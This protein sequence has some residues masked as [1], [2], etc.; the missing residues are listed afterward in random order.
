MK[1]MKRSFLA[2]MLA[3][4]MILGSGGQSVAVGVETDVAAETQED[5]ALPNEPEQTEQNGV[6][7]TEGSISVQSSTAVP[8]ARAVVMTDQ[9]QDG[10][11]V[12]Q[13][14]ASGTAGSTYFR[15]PSLITL[16]DGSLL[17]AADARW[18]DMSDGGGL[19]TLVSKST[20]NGVTWKYTFANYFGDNGNVYNS[21]SS[22][23][24]DPAMVQDDDGTIYL[25]VD[26][27]PGGVSNLN[28]CDEG[29]G[30]VSVNG[31]QRLALSTDGSNYDYYAGDFTDGYADICRISDNAPTGYVVNENYDLFSRSGDGQY[32][33]LNDNVFFSG[34]V[35]RVFPTSYLWLVTSEDGTDWSAPRIL[36]AQVKNSSETF[37]GV[38]PGRGLVTSSGRIIFPCYRHS[39]SL[40]PQERTSFIYSDDHGQTWRRTGD[41]SETSSE[42]AVTEADGR[43]YAFTRTGSSVLSDRSALT[44]YTSSDNGTSWSGRMDASIDT[45]TA[46]QMSAITYKEKIDGRTA[47]IL[48]APSGDNRTNG[49]IYVGLVREDGSLDWAY[50]CVVN[51]GS[52]EYSCLTE[53]ADGSI[54]I[55][56]EPGNGRI[57]YENISI[58][59]VAPGAQIG[60]A[61][62]QTIDLY[63]GDKETET[64]TV[65]GHVSPT[66][67]DGSI[68][69]VTAREA[70]DS[71]VG[72]ETKERT[73][74]TFT[75][76]KEGTT[77]VTA[78]DYVFTVNVHGTSQGD[79]SDIGDLTF[80]SNTGNS[81]YSL[82]KTVSHLILTPGKQYD[83]NVTGAE[84][85]TVT[86]NSGNRTVAAVDSNGVVTAFQQGD[87][88]IT[89]EI[90]N[91]DGVIVG[92]HT[93]TVSVLEIEPMASLW[94][95]NSR[96]VE[97]YIDQVQDSRLYYRQNDERDFKEVYADTV[98]Y[99]TSEEA[100]AMTFF[101]APSD[102]SYALTYLS[103][104]N[105]QNQN[106]W[107]V[108]E[109]ADSMAATTF[110]QNCGGLISSDLYS[111]AEVIQMLQRA[112]ALG[113]D[114]GFWFT[115]GKYVDGDSCRAVVNVVS[116]R[117]P[118]VEKSVTSVI[119]N[120]VETPYGEG[121][122]ICPGDTIV[123][124][125]AVHRYA[126]EYGITYNNASLTEE[127]DGAVFTSGS[128][129][130][131]IT[132]DLGTSPSEEEIFHY[133]ARYS[134]KESDGDAFL[135]N[136]VILSYDYHAQY[137]SGTMEAETDAE[138]KTAVQSFVPDDYVIDYGS[139][140]RVDF[141]GKVLH[142][143]T[144]GTAT[145]GSVE[146][147][148][149]KTVIYTPE[150]VLTEAD[151]V[152]LT[153]TEG[154]GY[155]FRVY[156]ATSVYY[157]EG[158]AEYS[159]GWSGYNRATDE[160][161]AS[162]AN[163][164]TVDLYGYDALYSDSNGNS[165][166][167]LA[168]SST[169]NAAAEFTFNGTG[170][171]IYGRTDAESG[172]I[173]MW[174][175]EGSGSD[176]ALL[177]LGYVDTAN[178]WLEENNSNY[179][180]TPIFNY[181]DLTPGTY[182]VRIVVEQGDVSLDGFRVYGTQGDAYETIYK[183]D[184]EDASQTW[185]LRDIVIAG[186][187]YDPED[188]NDWYTYGN[189][190]I[191]AVYDKT[192][193]SGAVILQEGDTITADA[194]MIN[195]GP[196]HEI[197]LQKG[198]TI[199]VGLNTASYEKV[200]VGMRSLNGGTVQFEQ[201]GEPAEINS[202]VDMYYEIIPK[203][204]AIVITNKG[205]A[206]LALTTIKVTGLSE[207]ISQSS[208]FTMDTDTMAYALQCIAG[209][210]APA[211][212]AEA[213]LTV[214]VMDYKGQSVAETVLTA[215]GTKG[216]TC[217]FTASDIQAAAED[218]LPDS[219]VLTGDASDTDVVYGENGSCQIRAGKTAVLNVTY[220][221]WLG[222]TVGT[223]QIVSPGQTS[224][225]N[226]YL[227][228]WNN[229]R[230]QVPKGYV[231]LNLLTLKNVSYGSEGSI[232]VTVF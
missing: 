196:K 224:G 30:Y 65:D 166:G 78:G 188:I 124:D 226:S 165:N 126:T 145:Y 200:A 39:G 56:Y 155:S 143:F 140:I 222:K 94:P 129:V 198:Q 221:N 31:I 102:D 69:S 63:L 24:I 109:D 202:T 203:D 217:T 54:G 83:L 142:D 219:Y 208:V 212:A 228:T 181:R 204:G 210:D 82:G 36:N 13:P 38:G 170:L 211:A 25:L 64:V 66:V 18:N 177:K 125:I 71:S 52:F 5:Q 185:K 169:R 159:R 48:S 58:D 47:I 107:Y 35:Y 9:P 89:A 2:L 139:P 57:I 17:A 201:N 97:I 163:D 108:I 3:F 11:T 115:R 176:R 153:N 182:T 127:L 174:L 37:Y 67:A 33:S 116:E 180:N 164:G 70:D 79:F 231:L 117:L 81:Q 137:S 12:G 53:Q 191:N 104:A 232:K 68:V 160:Q 44:Y 26:V 84:G 136:R 105:N 88:E 55:L 213:T 92:R 187:E 46:C 61:T 194:D 161:T 205:D 131:E 28:E 14:F 138:V 120:N 114:G 62:R 229:V 59:D 7:E 80:V 100:W 22:A 206:V 74:L 91:A 21:E 207:G 190:I 172:S 27:F 110:Y 41:L 16:Q 51:T 149:G 193:A 151:T 96:D 156:P 23:F 175:Y 43:L 6:Q 154:V 106:Q 122:Q 1:R 112:K 72:G 119:H 42:T 192:A 123:Y 87:T 173:S 118:S 147:E 60:D 75:A 45:W 167:S 150:R 157:E 99:I 215:A 141:T 101:G 168:I 20:D 113:A 95:T 227:F 184:K 40:I 29:T 162:A 86:W 179:Y 8:E 133:E 152:Y 93:A 103:A 186:S 49:R 183:G 77:T 220:R 216:K 144:E 189:E 4:T 171:D 223:A 134:V 132:D 199:A 128:A 230:K 197:Y 214:E 32:T 130:Q 178:N 15:I 34:A 98:I 218:V 73:E 90:R 85:Y 121:V 10:T 76:G 158:F 19:D 195:N 225:W 146:I 148:N 50:S 135:T 209:N 111:E